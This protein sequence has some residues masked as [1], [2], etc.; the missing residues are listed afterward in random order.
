MSA[1]GTLVVTDLDGTLLDHHTYQYDAAQAALALCRQRRIPL[2]FNT[3]KTL[4]E[5]QALASALSLHWPMVVENGSAIHLP[6]PLEGEPRAVILGQ[7]RQQLVAWLQRE[8]Q[9]AGFSVQ[10]FSDWSVA[11][12]AAHTGLSLAQAELAQQRE[13]SEPLLWQDTEHAFLTFQ[14]SARAQGFTLLKGGRFFHLLGQTD[15]GRATTWLRQ[16]YHTRS[17]QPV[18]IIALGDGHNDSA[19]L[20]AADVAVQIRSPVH[21][22]PPK[23]AAKRVIQ[24]ELCGPAGWAQALLSLLDPQP[25]AAH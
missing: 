13:Y 11:E 7:P 4:A 22:F 20:A 5:S 14:A 21:P 17:G 12:L 23:P 15:K 1:V 9:R 19:M 16:H 24:T 6:E 3:S 25:A 18:Q 8:R 10:G 2:I